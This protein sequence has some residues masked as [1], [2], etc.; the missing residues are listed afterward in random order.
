MRFSLNINDLGMSILYGTIKRHNGSIDIK[1]TPGKGTMF[2]IGLP[3]GKEKIAKSGE[4]SS[5]A[6]SAEKVNILIIDDE[7][8]IGAVL[9]EMLSKQGHQTSVFG[10]GKDGIEAFEKGDYEVLITD[11]GM[12]DISGWE[13]VDAARQIAPGVIS[14]I[15]TGWDIPE[16]EAKRKGVDFLINKPFGSNQVVQAVANAAKLKT[17]K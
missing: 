13:V 8:Q 1:T 7:P 16:A 14:G 2:T 17:C 5:H 6:I 11:L 10:S 4:E 12:P 15:I 9:S 3:K